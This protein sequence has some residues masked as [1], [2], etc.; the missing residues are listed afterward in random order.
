M[1]ICLLLQA[2]FLR[3]CMHSRLG[4]K[5]IG[6]SKTAYR[7]SRYRTYPYSMEEATS[8]VVCLG[9]NLLEQSLSAALESD[10]C[11]MGT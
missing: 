3:D 6:V 11:E 7:V 9:Y 5:E 8:V 1:S 10:R 2:G 4:Q